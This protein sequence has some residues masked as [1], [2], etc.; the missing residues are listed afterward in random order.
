MSRVSG[1]GFLYD[2]VQP[3][4][5]STNNAR[6]LDEDFKMHDSRPLR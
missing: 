1:V 6:I 3:I 5:S 2:Q 4:R